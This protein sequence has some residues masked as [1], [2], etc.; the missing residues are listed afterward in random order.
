MEIEAAAGELYISAM[1]K[2]RE[3]SEGVVDSVRLKV[4]MNLFRY[5]GDDEVR[6]E[7]TDGEDRAGTV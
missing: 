1:M 2:V 7:G 3:H 6:D 5:I 4:L